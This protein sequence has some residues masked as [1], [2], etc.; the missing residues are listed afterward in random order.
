MGTKCKRCG[1]FEK[2]TLKADDTFD[3]WELCPLEFTPSPE[4]LYTHFKEKEFNITLLC[5]NCRKLATSF[6]TPFLH[7]LVSIV[8][9]VV[10]IFQIM[11]VV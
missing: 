3:E 2:D 1:L 10:E 9:S 6:T 5:P 8:A 11:V 7:L 4:G